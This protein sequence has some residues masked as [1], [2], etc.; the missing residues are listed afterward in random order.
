MKNHS[1]VHSGLAAAAMLLMAA[2]TAAQTTP[3][4]KTEHPRNAASGQTASVKNQHT[5]AQSSSKSM[6][7]AH[8]TESLTAP[9]PKAKTP[10]VEYKDPEDMTTRYR[11]GNNKTTK[12]NGKSQNSTTPPPQ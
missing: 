5:T 4:S 8:A 10:A 9:K 6:G 3:A 1:Y 12:I 2:F 7:S 11:P